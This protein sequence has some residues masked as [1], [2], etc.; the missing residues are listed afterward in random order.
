VLAVPVWGRFMVAATT[1][2]RPEW[3]SAPANITSV[4]ICRLS[5]KL[6]TD[7]CREAAPPDG[8]RGNGGP[9]VYTEYF[10]AGTEPTDT[11]PIHRRLLP[12]PLRALAGLFSPGHT[13]SSTEPVAPQAPA[14]HANEAPPPPAP[15]ATSQPE[16]PKKKGFW[17][18]VFG[19][20]KK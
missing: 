7:S 2:D 1:K 11:C 14:P 17:S 12:S 6:A 3:F 5:G 8:E 20:N 15:Q 19:G 16:Q 13:A 4:A 18:R 9:M 10:V